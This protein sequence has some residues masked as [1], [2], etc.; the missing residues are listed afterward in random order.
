MSA[1]DPDS[2]TEA[3]TERRIQNAL[4]EGNTPSSPD[5]ALL[6]SLAGLALVL[7][8]FADHLMQGMSLLLSRLLE[9]AGEW[10]LTALPDILVIAQAVG[11]QLA[12]LLSGALVIASLCGLAGHFANG[13]PRA[14]AKRITPDFS[15][16]SPA[17]GLSR[18]IGARAFVGF[19]KNVAKFLAAAGIAATVLSMQSDDILLAAQRDASRLGRLA[20]ELALRCLLALTAATAVIA[21]LDLVWSRWKWLRDMR[22]T[23]Q[24]VKDELKTT[25]GS[26]MVRARLRSLAQSRARQRMMTAVPRATMVIANP[27][28]YAVALRYVAGETDAPLVLAKGRDA[29]ALRIRT[30]AEEAGIPV[31]ED[32]PLA[33]SMHDSC[34][35]DKVIPAEFYHAIAA[36]IHTLQKDRANRRSTDHAVNLPATPTG[37]PLRL[38]SVGTGE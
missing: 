31:I 30:R 20:I 8:F 29:V 17:K 24:E 4:E 1:D 34:A 11:L 37:D 33:R 5:M 22:M 13:L 26:P 15:R 35:V 21:V 28:H 18:M 16:I 36:L 9:Q 10:T 3:P 19:F 14:A 25:E 32:K 7:A 27:T 38:R 23:R 2:K 6:G 12:A